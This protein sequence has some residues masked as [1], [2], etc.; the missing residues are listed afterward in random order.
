MEIG[1]AVDADHVAFIVSNEALGQDAAAE[2]G[3]HGLEDLVARAALVPDANFVVNGVLSVVFARPEIEV[4]EATDATER[5]ATG[6]GA[7]THAVDVDIEAALVHHHGDVVPTSHLQSAFGVH[8]FLAHCIPTGGESTVAIGVEHEL[9]PATGLEIPVFE[10]L[11]LDPELD[12]AVIIGVVE[13]IGDAEAVVVELGGDI[14]GLH[15]HRGANCQA[16]T[17]DT[18]VE[19][20]RNAV[21]AVAID[22]LFALFGVGDLHT[23]LI[24]VVL[25]DA[26]TA[27]LGCIPSELRAFELQVARHGVLFAVDDTTHRSDLTAG[28]GQHA[29]VALE[30]ERSFHAVLVKFVVD[31]R[32]IIDVSATLGARSDFRLGASIYIEEE[33]EGLGVIESFAE[34]GEVITE[35]HRLVMQLTVGPTSEHGHGR[36]GVKVAVVAVA[37]PTEVVEFDGLFG[38]RGVGIRGHAHRKEHFRTVGVIHLHFDGAQWTIVLAHV[39]EFGLPPAAALLAHFFA[40]FFRDAVCGEAVSIRAIDETIVG[41]SAPRVGDDPSAHLVFFLFAGFSVAVEVKFEAVVVAYD[42]E[43]VVN[44]RTPPANVALSHYAGLEVGGSFGNTAL[45]AGRGHTDT[46]NTA[47]GEVGVAVVVP[48]PVLQQ[49]ATFLRTDVHRQTAGLPH[50]VE[51]GFVPFL[52][53]RHPAVVLAVPFFVAEEGR[54]AAAAVGFH[55]RHTHVLHKLVLA[56]VAVSEEPHEV[57]GIHIFGQ[58]GVGVTEG[59]Q[60]VREHVSDA[61]C[62]AARTAFLRDDGRKVHRGGI[63]HVVGA[64][65]LGGYRRSLQAGT[66]T[67][68]QQRTVGTHRG[69][70]VGIFLTIHNELCRHRRREGDSCQTD[71]FENAFHIGNMSVWD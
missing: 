20:G 16:L 63:V 60:L 19:H 56:R 17:L 12:G 28:Y 55:R 24:D 46:G 36:C 9:S 32:H 5:G 64:L 43:S 4:A 47:A 33:F 22:G 48:Q 29:V 50:A 67:V 39:V 34:V 53:T 13:D 65:T 51:H 11:G 41:P 70:V 3:V 14:G 69:V 35:L 7:A 2:L 71:E 52:I 45:C 44:T 18:A 30:F 25:L 26:V 37:R 15:G 61:R 68:A 57:R 23:V 54:V 27:V 42:G 31:D 58:R 10:A 21:S 6:D 1:L 59:V 66:R 40:A 38:T 8:T 49:V 62:R